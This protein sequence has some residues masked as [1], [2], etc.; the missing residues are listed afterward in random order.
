MKIV[1]V[2]AIVGGYDKLKHLHHVNSVDD[3]P[4]V[5]FTDDLEQESPL[6]ELR[7]ACTI[8]S[9]CWDAESRNAKHHKVMIHEYFDC[10]YSLWI[11]GN[12][13][14]LLSPSNIID[15][16]LKDCD[17]ATFKHPARNCAYD[18]LEE[19]VKCQLDKEELMRR[20]LKDYEAEGFP[21]G[22]G[23]NAG[24]FILR[25]HT[26]QIK[27]FNELWWEQICKYSRRDQLSLNYVLWKTGIKMGELDNYWSGQLRKIVNHGQ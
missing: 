3:T 2:T 27:E 17:I 23:L 10:E 18:E 19:C 24:G 11:D 14:L 25:R 8:F 21:R 12:N 5:C 9:G 1:C 4:Y 13:T 16:Y 15:E 6:W 7:P 22:F 20:Q 26:D